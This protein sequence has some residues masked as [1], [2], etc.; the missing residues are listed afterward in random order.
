MTTLSR[1]DAAQKGEKNSMIDSKIYFGQLKQTVKVQ[2]TETDKEVFHIQTPHPSTPPPNHEINVNDY[3]IIGPFHF[4][5][6]ILMKKKSVLC[7]LFTHVIIQPVSK[8]ETESLKQKQN[9]SQTF[10]LLF[11]IIYLCTQSE[12]QRS[13][14]FL[15]IQQG[16][17]NSSPCRPAFFVS[18]L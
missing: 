13:L 17:I 2:R 4:V 18:H 12:Y 15:L 16:A 5:S 8:K 6:V 9:K 1:K 14:H 3:L 10:I 11:I 7:F